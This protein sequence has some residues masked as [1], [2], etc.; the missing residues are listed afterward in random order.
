MAELITYFDT[1]SPLVEGAMEELLRRV[2]VKR[3]EKGSCLLKKGQTCRHLYFMQE[4]LMKSALVTGE[5]EFIMRFFYENLLFS[6]FDSYFTQTPSKYSLIALEPCSLTLI[7]AETMTELCAR[8]HS[9]ETFFRKLVSVAT[10]K[11]TKRIGEML[12]VNARD[13][14][15]QFME[16]NASIAQRISLGDLA[17]YLGITQQSL[18]RIRAASVK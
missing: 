16:E 3:V 18:S 10:V 9:V 11:M 15:H 17:K 7:D 4:G 5:K 14:Y 13:H 1:F 12:E 2:Q 6:V 8:Y